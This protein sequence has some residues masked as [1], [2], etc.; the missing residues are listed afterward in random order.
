MVSRKAVAALLVV[1]AAAMLA[2]RTEAFVP[3]FTYGELQRMQ[4]KERS[5]GQKKSLSVWQRSGEEGP[6]DPAELIEE[7]GNEMIKLTAPLEIGMRMNSRQLEKYRAALEGL[8]NE[9]LPQHGL[10][11]ESSYQNKNSN[12]EQETLVGGTLNSPEKHSNLPWAPT[13]AT[14]HIHTH[15]QHIY[16]STPEQ[17]Q[18]PGKC[19]QDAR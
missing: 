19:C 13:P 7:E 16:R 4:E 6:V 3:I 14:L 17:L 2:S 9:M 12:A 10:A 15:F 11:T 1:H 5:K 8:L 18:V